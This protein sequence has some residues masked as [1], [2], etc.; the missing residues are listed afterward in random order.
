MGEAQ[1][2]PESPSLNLAEF[3]RPCWG[4]G[5]R[6]KEDGKKDKCVRGDH[7]NF[8]VS[9]Y[10]HAFDGRMFFFLDQCNFSNFS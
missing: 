7:S 6:S 4:K 10:R 9:C 1:A 2:Q 8:K 5:L 3:C